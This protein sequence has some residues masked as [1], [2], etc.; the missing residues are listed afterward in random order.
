MLDREIAIMK[1]LDHVNVV[2]L[3][4]VIEDYDTNEVFLGELITDDLDWS[5]QFYR[6]YLIFRMRFP[7][8]PSSLSSEFTT[9][10]QCFIYWHVFPPFTPVLGCGCAVMEFVENGPLMPDN[11]KCDP[12]NDDQARLYFRQLISALEYCEF[13]TVLPKSEFTFFKKNIFSSANTLFCVLTI[14]S[15]LVVLG[16]RS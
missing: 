11:K 9:S 10:A 2:K 13:S 4:Q 7:S 15:L 5:Q 1:K 16:F 8:P 6:I 3:Y 14:T 12:L